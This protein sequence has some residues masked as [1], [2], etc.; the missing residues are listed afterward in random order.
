MIVRQLE[1]QLQKA[2]KSVASVALV[3]PR[4][5]GKTTTALKVGEKIPSVYLDLENSAD[6]ARIRDIYLFFEENKDK[7]IILDE[8]QRAP[9]IFRE[10]R[11]LIDRERRRGRKTGLFLFLGS[12]SMDLM[13]QSGESLA[14]RISYLE[15]Y[16]LNWQEFAIRSPEGLNKLWNRGGFP[17]SLLADSD[18]ESFSWR[19]DF[20]RTYLERDIPVLGPRVPAQTLDR[21]WTMLAHQQGSIINA[22]QLARNIDVSATTVHRYI[23][24]MADLLLV[25]R[26]QPWSSNA[27]KRLVKSPRIF[28]RD[29]GI[30]HALLNI[31]TLDQLTSHPVCGA[32]WE[33]MVIENI[34]SVCRPHVRSYFFRSAQGAEIDLILESGAEKPWAIEIKRSSA[35]VVTKGFHIACAVIAASRRY[36]VYSGTETFSLSKD[37]KAVPL[38]VMMDLVKEL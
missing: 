24:L 5:V 1:T 23:D 37:I 11:G 34:L 18:S 33:G 21:F 13:Q 3:G 20:I 15:L 30:V 28:I 26:L 35:P 7:L 31:V 27:G 38:S 22:A 14:G 6:A 2:L 12:A 19:R 16:P 29:S 10:I 17:E 25:R 4:Q 36:V 32:S 9:E 8:V